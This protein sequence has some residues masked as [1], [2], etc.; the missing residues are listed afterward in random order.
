MKANVISDKMALSKK[1]LVVGIVSLLYWF[2]TFFMERLVFVPDA[3]RS[4]VFTYVVIKLLTLLTIYCLLMFFV[5]ALSGWKSRSPEA[6]TLKYTLP[7]F[8][9]VTAFWL[10]CHAWPLSYG[11]QLNIINAAYNYNNFGG[12]FNYLTTYVF[13]IGMNLF[14]SGAF[15]VAFKIFLV[16]L[17]AGYCIYRLRKLNGGWLPF[18][19]YGPFLVP[20]GLYLSYTVHRIPIY[21]VLYLAFS[22]LIICDHLEGKSLGRGKFVL[23]SF[24]IAMLTQ[25]RSEGIYLLVLGPVLLYVCYKPKLSTRA[26]ALALAVMMAAQVLVAV[27]QKLETS[28]ETGSRAMPFFEYVITSMERKGLDKEKNAEDLALVDKYISLDG[29]HELNEKYG[30]GNYGDNAIRFMSDAVNENASAEEQA[31]FRSAVIRLI[32]KNP[33]VYLKSQLGAWHSISVGVSA[34]RKLDVIANVFTDLYV[35]TIILL[36]F[37]LWTMLKK[38]WCLWWLTSCHLGHM[39][40]TTALLPAAYF[41][42]YY[43]QYLFAV[44]VAVLVLQLCLKHRNKKRIRE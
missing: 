35:P 37:W 6:E 17:G 4:R 15:S 43:Q 25:W 18:L 3:A 38:K 14:P 12:F 44:L 23:L 31:D 30:D 29:I 7:P 9:L 32:I 11:D 19:I 34:E 26:K 24:V 8:V 2:A 33:W 40:I 13:M 28:G 1:Q 27:P 20:P 16:S 41:K 5:N 21:A 42:Y 10:Y 22:C 36:A 39:V